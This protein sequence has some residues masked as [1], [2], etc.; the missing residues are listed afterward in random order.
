MKVPLPPDEPQGGQTV[1][2]IKSFVTIGN[3]IILLFTVVI[4]STAAVT[5]GVTLSFSID[6][7]Q[8]IGV[9]HAEI[10]SREVKTQ[11]ETFLGQPLGQM[12]GLLSSS[13]YLNTSLPNETEHSNPEW[14][15]DFFRRHL[16]DRVAAHEAYT[17]ASIGF[18]DANYVSCKFD[19]LY[20]PDVTNCHVAL[21]KGRAA[22]NFTSLT[23]EV[24]QQ[25]HLRDDPF[26]WKH[27]EIRHKKIRPPH[28][29]MV[30]NC[31][32]SKKATRHGLE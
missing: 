8:D 20:R 25:N 24:L 29:R 6:A 5:L 19:P 7:I 32:K 28:T 4:F 14:Y 9:L 21:S 15:R 30:S 23:V 3:V 27:Q 13:M 11:I 31:R 1:S 12:R 17:F 18:E 16:S 2:F 26:Q 10:T 22:R